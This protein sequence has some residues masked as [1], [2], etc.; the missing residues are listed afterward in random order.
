MTGA[1]ALLR[2]IR[3][4]GG[5]RRLARLAVA[6]VVAA[7]TELTGLA[8]L[9]CATWLLVTAADQPPISALTVA[10]VGVRTFAI[11]RGLGRYLDRLVSHDAAL[12]VLA[13][14]RTAVFAAMARPA[15]EPDTSPDEG[16]RLARLVEDVDSVQD[17]LLRCLL[18]AGVTVLAGGVTLAVTGAVLPAAVLPLAVGLIVVGVLLPVA[19]FGAARRAADGLASARAAVVGAAVDVSH[20]AADLIATG[21]VA[22]AVAVAAAEADRVAAVER[23]AGRVAAAV[24]GVAAVV[25]GLTAAGVALVAAPAVAAG[26]TSGAY[27]AV[28]ILLALGKVEAAGVLPDA[29][30]RYAHLRGALDRVLAVLAPPT[31][32]PAVPA[33]ATGAPAPAVVAGTPAPPVD[34][35][36]RG[37]RA[38]YADD[39]APALDGIDLDVGPGRRVALVGPSGSG[40]ST[41]LAV[42]AGTVVPE[43]GSVGVA[44]AAPDPETAWRQVSGVM[45]DAHVFHASVGENVSLGRPGVDDDAARAALRTAGLPGW[46]DALDRVVGEDG[47]QLSGGERQRLLL[48]RA[49][50]VPPPVLLLDE[51]TEG[52]DPAAAAEVLR[53]VLAAVPRAA[54]VVAAHQLAVV[55]DADEIVVLD[56]GRVL[57]R[58]DHAGLLAQQGWYAREWAAQ[59]ASAEGYRAHATTG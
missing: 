55:A 52:L 28:V 48:A 30:T 14:V 24:G 46:A 43:A 13:D 7:G 19:A 6:G 5:G 45:A 23:R 18:P 38:R 17:V 57:E 15:R 41:V 40:K 58:G 22:A 3:R 39:R 31:A 20:G 11:A 35:R 53:A 4:L 29:A 9:G 34:V 47:G 44:G 10:I 49:L 51:P 36:L 37:V 12:R 16:D 25:P 33:R 42:I 59:V 2:E 21:A 26:E 54:V 8:L 50:A 27:A 56:A 1:G 32:A